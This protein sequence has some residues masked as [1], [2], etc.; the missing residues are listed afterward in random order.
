MKM[1]LVAAPLL[2]L[3]IAT[4]M[5]QTGVRLRG[6]LRSTTAPERLSPSSGEM[7]D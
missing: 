7:A 4:S 5:F 3:G 6:L 2:A 1:K